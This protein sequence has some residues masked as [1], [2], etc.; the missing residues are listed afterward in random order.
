MNTDGGALT[1]IDRLMDEL[2]AAMRAEVDQLQ[3]RRRQLN[4]EIMEVD[5]QLKRA[6]RFLRIAAPVAEPKPKPKRK[7]PTTKVAR[8]REEEV[9]RLLREHPDGMT[10]DGIARALRWKL[11]TARVAVAQARDRETV[12]MAAA[13]AGNN[14]ALWRAYDA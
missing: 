12:R 7:G 2:G 4:T 9:E 1:G 5:A 14:G 3:A 13:P 6:D 8:W 10:V 11:A